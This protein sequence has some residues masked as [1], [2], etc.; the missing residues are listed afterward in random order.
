MTF[1]NPSVLYAL[2]A[3][4]LPLLIHFFAR[5]RAKVLPF[6]SLRF[7][8]EL[9]QTE[10]RRFRLREWLLLLLRT[11]AVALAV[12]AF[13][14]P[15]AVPPGVNPKAVGSRVAAAV[16]LDDSYSMQVATPRGSLFQEACDR[17]EQVLATLDPADAAVVIRPRGKAWVSKSLPVRSVGSAEATRARKRWAEEPRGAYD[18]D[19]AGGLKTAAEWFARFPG[20]RHELYL[21]SDFAGRPFAPGDSTLRPGSRDWQ[22]FLLPVSARNIPNAGVQKAKLESQI[23]E[24]GA[25]VQVV[26]GLANTGTDPLDERLVQLS[27]QGRPV[28]QTTV[29]LKP[30]E[31]ASV[32]LR[33]IPASSGWQFGA[34]SLEDDALATDN[35]FWFAVQVPGKLQVLVVAGTRREAQPVAVALS[36]PGAE[37]QIYDVTVKSPSQVASADLRNADAVFLVDVNSLPAVGWSEIV[38][39][40]R[41]GGT[42]IVFPGP[43]VEPRVLSQQLLAPLGLPP[44]GETLGSPGA[45]VPV[46]TLGQVDLNHPLFQGVFEKKAQITSPA[47]YVVLHSLSSPRIRPVLS[48]SDGSPMLYEATVDAGEVFVFTTGVDTS[49]SDLTRRG[50]FVPLVVR[51]PIY[52]QSKGQNTVAPATVGDKLKLVDQRL[53][54]ENDYAVRRPNG[55]VVKLIPRAVGG[56]VLLEYDDTDVPGVYQLLAGQEVVHIWAVNPDPSEAN[57]KQADVKALAAWLGAR[58]IPPMAE[59]GEIV[60]ATRQGRELWPYL[61]ALLFVV[62]LAE[63]ILA[64][65]RPAEDE[66]REPETALEHS[67]GGN[68]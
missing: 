60:Q 48:Y 5:R 28:D 35:S 12:L 25:A 44:L 68:V 45:A 8:K 17:V 50:V 49:W 3:V 14:R 42:L 56:G 22:V 9:Q 37:H 33:V 41:Q 36:P 67:P 61:S 1:L 54:L 46:L 52:G 18:T 66:T 62:L 20:S 63:T 23:L 16:V 2:P 29:T 53:P 11:L 26:G 24:P 65:T 31:A 13:A 4:T 51:L 55:V 57:L 21:V 59:L 19:L 43:Q 64:R 39:F 6:S 30:G 27:W 58:V 15:V 40:V 47:F 38:R 10:I 7:L 34:V 32:R